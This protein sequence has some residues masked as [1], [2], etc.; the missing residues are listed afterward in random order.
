LTIN[1]LSSAAL[2]IHK[3]IRVLLDQTQILLEEIPQ[4]LFFQEIFP[5]ALFFNLFIHGD[6][7]QNIPSYFDLGRRE[8]ASPADY[9]VFIKAKVLVEYFREQM[10]IA[11]SNYTS[12]PSG[13][14][15]SLFDRVFDRFMV[16]MEGKKSMRSRQLSVSTL[17]DKYQKKRKST[18]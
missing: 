8:F 11:N 15:N 6:Q 1:F 16:L 7:L 12:F 14:F 3:Q 2:T 4:V 17:Y 13:E 10:A 9:D 18:N 5:S